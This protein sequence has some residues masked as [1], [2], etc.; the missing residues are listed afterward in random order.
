MKNN[1]CTFLLGIVKPVHTH[2]HI[3]QPIPSA[4]HSGTERLHRWMKNYAILAFL[5][6]LLGFCRAA[7]FSSVKRKLL[8][9]MRMSWT[10]ACIWLQSFSLSNVTWVSTLESFISSSAD[11]VV[12]AVIS[13]GWA[14]KRRLPSHVFE[15]FKCPVFVASS[16][17]IFVSNER[18]WTFQCASVDTAGKKKRRFKSAMW[19][20][21]CAPS[22]FDS[23]A[24]VKS[25]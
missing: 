5:S 3:H 6:V 16:N 23:N 12:V 21:T 19:E 17:S 2:T 11:V 4:N 14:T 9:V 18:V 15:S 7:D 8:L 20:S 25:K 13:F 1:R 24:R 10:L 22:T